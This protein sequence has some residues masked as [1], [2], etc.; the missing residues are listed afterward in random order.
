[1][2]KYYC[3]ECGKEAGYITRRELTAVI[4]GTLDGTHTWKRQYCSKEC[5]EKVRDRVYKAIDKALKI[6][7]AQ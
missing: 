7:K 5:Y 4:E 3:D 6:D 1:M 2:I